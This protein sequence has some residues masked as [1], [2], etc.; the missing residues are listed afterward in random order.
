ML[1][2]WALKRRFPFMNFSV[3]VRG[4]LPISH[5]PIFQ[6][7]TVPTFSGRGE[8]SEANKLVTHFNISIIN[9]RRF[10]KNYGR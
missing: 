8:M 3:P 4:M 9:R 5:F 1:E 2:Y 7:P 6:E 10:D